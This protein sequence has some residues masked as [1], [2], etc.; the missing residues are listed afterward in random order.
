MDMKIIINTLKEKGY[1]ITA[2]RKMIVS[3]LIEQKDNLISAYFINEECNKR[4]EK[5]NISTV[6][7]NLDVLVESDLLHRFIDDDGNALYKLKCKDSHHHHLICTV[8]GK[9]E[10]INYCPLEK[11]QALSLEKSF[12]LTHHKIELYGYCKK[13]TPQ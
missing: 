4:H 8:C 10:V 7:R 2:Q 3:I 9:T 6:Y 13:C 12:I 11:L 1:K 5:A